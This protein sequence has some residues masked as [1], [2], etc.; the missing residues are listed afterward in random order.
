[1]HSIF[2]TA[3]RA[4]GLLLVT[5]AI[6][7]TARPTLADEQPLTTVDVSPNSSIVDQGAPAEAPESAPA[8]AT[9]VPSTAVPSTA[10]ATAATVAQATPVPTATP[11]AALTSS[12]AGTVTSERGP[13][14]GAKIVARGAGVTLT[15][16][17]AKD[18]TFFFDNLPVGTYRI[19]ATA[20]GFEPLTP[21]SVT[22]DASVQQILSI[23]LSVPTLNSLRTVAT[24]SVQGRNSS[25]AINTSG[26]SQATVGSQVFLERGDAQIQNILEEYPGVELTR[27]SSGGAPGANTDI[28]IRGSSTYET[29]TLIDGHPITAG[30]FGTFLIQFLNPLVLGSVEVDKGPGVLGNTIQ[31][32][33][34]GTANFRTPTISNHLEGRLTTGY[35]SFNGSTYSARISDTIGKVG[36]LAAYGFNGTPGYFN[37]N[38]FS[39]T[40]AS[41]SVPGA[42]PPSAVINQAVGAGESYQNRSQVFKLAYNFS[43]STSLTLGA[44]GEQTYVDYTATLDTVEP[45]TIVSALP[46]GDAY[47]NGQYNGYVGKTILASSTS[48]NLYV[49]NY[50]LDNEPIFTA[51]LRTTIGPGAFLGRF[52]TGA[53]NRNI[54]DP[55]E[56]TQINHCGD[57]STTICASPTRDN[58]FYQA[59][60][61]RLHGAD[62]QFSLPIGQYGQH[63]ATISYDQ[64]SDESLYCSGQYATIPLSSC[65]IN[66]LILTSR[67][68]SIRALAL[69]APRL[70]VGFGNYFSDTTLVGSRYD[71]RATLVWTPKPNLA[72]RFA[73]GTAYVAPPTNFAAP[74]IGAAAAEASKVIVNNVL[75]VNDSLKPET[76]AGINLGADIGVHGDS[77]FT[78]DLYETA[79]TNRFA[80]VTV[81]ATGKPPL[82]TYQGMPFNSISESYN[83]SDANQE[84]IE[85][86]YVR[87][88]RYG[89][90]GNFSF[91]LLRA[92]NYNTANPV[93]PGGPS[94]SDSQ[95]GTIGGNGS[96][97]PGYQIPGF[98]YSHG[99]AQ[100]TYAF[101]NSARVAF[102][103]TIYGA[104]NSFGEPGFSLFDFNTSVPLN[105]GIRLN[106]SVSNLFDHDDNRTL[107]E[108]AYGYVVPGV[109]N[110]YSLFFAPPRRVNFQLVFPFGD[111]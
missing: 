86:G 84:G 94:V 70:K 96:E 59:E 8:A 110:R 105:F 68:F 50:E 75:Y 58:P 100:L 67:T 79:L 9:A 82:G 53:I 27:A 98:P 2:A 103:A 46:G 87:N 49:G 34:G 77:K 25:T 62:G 14:A 40:A 30:R 57:P 109:A 6:A 29:Q 28:A 39:V 26:A 73:V 97:L 71:P 36:F 78:L 47:N 63:L 1:M 101:P 111:R 18:G 66:N 88:P 90:G 92:Y 16:T 89:L 12:I 61:D 55:A 54:D 108:Y 65:S 93:F 106:A 48:D 38:I 60:V 56:A 19:T 95:T 7:G 44:I 99:R 85:F 72:Y 102:G 104:N 13:V 10:A 3:R 11:S 17:S 91:D 69:V 83:A 21:T 32:A 4:V 45:F 43:K 37:G 23:S 80:T 74:P 24:I 107:G 31:N 5:T 22:T 76:S 52:Y 81:N 41:N 20:Q 64:H 51:D 15:T 35:D 42:T 33:I